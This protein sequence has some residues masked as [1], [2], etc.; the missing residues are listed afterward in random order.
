[1]NTISILKSTAL[2]LCLVSGLAACAATP[3]PPAPPPVEP[4][5]VNTCQTPSSKSLQIAIAA[6]QSELSHRECHYQFDAMHH[7]L[8][9]IAQGDPSPKNGKKFLDFYKWNVSQGILS[10]K[11]GKDYY[12]RYFKPT[13]GNVLSNDRNVCSLGKNKDALIKSL[14]RELV[15]KKTGLQVIMQ[16]RNA[17]FEAL[18]IHNDLIFLIET[19]L[20]ACDGAR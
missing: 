8:L 11:Q 2:S 12:N 15:D 19:T 3:P 18:R 4:V 14:G 17:Y 16:D 9:Q 5:V 13:F 7:T 1:M 10:S 6:A 20:M